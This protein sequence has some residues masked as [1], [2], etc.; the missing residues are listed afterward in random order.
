MGL[1]ELIVL[2]AGLAMDAFAVSVCKGLAMKKITVKNTLICGAWFGSFQ[3]IMPLIGYFAGI[4]FASYI[5]DVDH[6]IAF[7]L[8]VLIGI[9]MIKEAFS[10]DDGEED[11]SV[12]FR[13]MFVMAI[14]TSIDA[15]AVGVT[16]V[17]VPVDVIADASIHMNTL[18]GSGLIG[19]ITFAITCAGVK[20][21]SIFG[22]RYK[23][24][25]EIAGGIVL[26]L[27]G[28]KVLAEH[29]IKSI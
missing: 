4:R 10:D 12:N 5:V 7:A 25:A 19:V 29:L 18:F 20:I 15:L 17:C 16:F 9:N 8:L 28:I 11:E 21:G 3:A 13:I 6:W 23:S 1:F 2:A 24:K 22:D 14:V 27:L 26:I